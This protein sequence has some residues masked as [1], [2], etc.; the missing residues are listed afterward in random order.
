MDADQRTTS[1]SNG[2]RYVSRRERTFPLLFQFNPYKASLPLAAHNVPVR[3]CPP[4]FTS[5]VKGKE[6]QGAQSIDK[7]FNQKFTAVLRCSSYLEADIMS[8]NE[9]SVRELRELLHKP[10]NDTCADCGAPGECEQHRGRS[11]CVVRGGCGCVCGGPVWR[12]AGPASDASTL[13][14]VFIFCA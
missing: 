13:L 3:T 10:G 14:A 11:W 8:S 9:R 5:S 7:T 12:V 2:V 4:P 1:E 6:T